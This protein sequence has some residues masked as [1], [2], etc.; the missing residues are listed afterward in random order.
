MSFPAA[1]LPMQLLMRLVLHHGRRFPSA[2]LGRASFFSL[3]TILLLLVSSFTNFA[4]PSLMS[5]I[6]MRNSAGT[7]SRLLFGS[8]KVQR[9][10]PRLQINHISSIMIVLY[11]NLGLVLWI[12][13]CPMATRVRGTLLSCLCLFQN[14]L[15]QVLLILLNLRFSTIQYDTEIVRIFFQS[16]C[17][18]TSR[19]QDS[20]LSDLVEL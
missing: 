1:Q 8:K 13:A 12:G 4:D 20:C 5:M 2:S 16:F 6:L 17:E 3:V 18:R 10:L 19:Y 11:V 15:V 7:V 9:I 14:L